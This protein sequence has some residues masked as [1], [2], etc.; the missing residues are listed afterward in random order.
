MASQDLA[1]PTPIK[2]NSIWCPRTLSAATA[3]PEM[4]AGRGGSLISSAAN[5]IPLSRTRNRKQRNAFVSWGM[6]H[7]K[8]HGVGWEENLPGEPRGRA[9]GVREAGSG[10]G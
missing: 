6:S 7:P 3:L 2:E 9:G 5:W 4:G 8:Y 1:A 10:H